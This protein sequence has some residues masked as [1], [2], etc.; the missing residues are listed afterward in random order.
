M[1]WHL[2]ATPDMKLFE[3]ANHELDLLHIA[4]SIK[5]LVARSHHIHL[6]SRQRQ[7]QG[8][9]YLVTSG[10]GSERYCRLA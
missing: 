2:I 6:D 1:S 9:S 4:R 3:E 8:E 5:L 10:A 7:E